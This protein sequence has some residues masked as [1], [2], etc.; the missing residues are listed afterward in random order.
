MAGQKQD[1]QHEHTFSSYVRIRNVALN[2]CQR[3][4]TIGKSGERESVISVLVARHDYDDDTGVNFSITLHIYIYV[5]VW[6]CMCVCVC[7]CVWLLNEDY[8]PRYFHI[9]SFHGYFGATVGVC[10]DAVVTE[11]TCM[12][13]AT[14]QMSRVFANG[15][16]DRGLIPGRVIPKNQKMVRIKSKVE[17][18][19]EWSSALPCTSVL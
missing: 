1:D 10:V 19:S 9:Y 8:S 6:V 4:W 16:E 18:S 13:Q 12:Y 14:G 2:T 3:R 11:Y 7:V 17:Q 5:C 15:P